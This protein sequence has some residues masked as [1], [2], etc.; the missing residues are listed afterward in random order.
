MTAL[1]NVEGALPRPLWALT[2]HLLATPGMR[3][4]KERVGVFLS[5]PSLFDSGTDSE[6]T[7]ERTIKVARELEIVYEEDEHLALTDKVKR[8]AIDDVEGFYDVL[9][10]AVIH[11]VPASVL[12]T[13]P[14]NTEGKDLL[15]ALC[16]FMTLAT[17]RAVDVNT[18]GKMQARASS[19]DF[20]NPFRNTARW[21]F[22]PAWAEALGFAA[23]PLLHKDRAKSLVPDCRKA[24]RRIAL[25]K[26]SVG[27]SLSPQELITGLLEE[28]PVLPGG[29]LSRAMGFDSPEG[30]VS[31]A[32]SAALLAGNDDGWLILVSRSD[33]V[34]TIHLWDPDAGSGS[35][36][37]SAAEI[38]T[39]A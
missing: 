30:V 2:R 18:F 35:R 37:F 21:N 31:Q 8:L 5:P 17:D 32:L 24:V 39:A 9:R 4:K 27:T 3:Q 22:F 6:R 7:L 1:I 23:T 38:R 10:D 13:D 29:S 36:P 19:D 14:S 25:H 16:F 20:R 26:W 34:N 28:L 15:R 33:A 12:A 11:R